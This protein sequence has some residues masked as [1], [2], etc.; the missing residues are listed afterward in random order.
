MNITVDDDVK[1]V[2]EMMQRNIPANR[3][4]AVAR[5]VEKIA[6]ILWGQYEIEEVKP[7]CLTDD[8]I[9][10]DDLHTRLTSTEQFLDS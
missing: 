6:P 9:F 8:A 3:L 4:V 1:S 5:G 7:L 10:R 2:L